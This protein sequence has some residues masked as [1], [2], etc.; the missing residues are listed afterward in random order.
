MEHVKP[1]F[2]WLETNDV[3]SV[4]WTNVLNGMDPQMNCEK[5]GIRDVPEWMDRPVT[6]NVRHL[7]QWLSTISNKINKNFWK[8]IDETTDLFELTRY[9]GVKNYPLSASGMA[10]LSSEDIYICTLSDGLKKLLFV[11]PSYK[12]H[13]RTYQLLL[14]SEEIVE[15][16]EMLVCPGMIFATDVFIDPC[17]IE[18][19]GLKTFFS[20]GGTVDLKKNEAT[21]FNTR[22]VK[23]KVV[24]LLLGQ[25]PKN[26]RS[27][28]FYTI[29]EEV[30]G[31][32]DYCRYI[33]YL[34]KQFDEYEGDKLCRKRICDDCEIRFNYA[35]RL[36]T[37]H[38]RHLSTIL[39]ECLL[40][41][42]VHGNFLKALNN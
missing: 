5:H 20:V 2:E 35:K 17:K 7:L 9:Y 28:L 41:L 37:T 16:T 12:H 40:Y 27:M 36:N 21:Y 39:D 32:C 11:S 25:I 3:P 30:V 26:M 42:K 14:R 4:F 31:V 38:L 24:E 15:K 10:Q 13:A 6:G 34:S 33:T 23:R 22:E 1:I 8:R 18:K 29:K 19:V